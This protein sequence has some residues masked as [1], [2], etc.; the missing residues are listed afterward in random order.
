M[1]TALP[2][3]QPKEQ[4]SLEKMVAFLAAFRHWCGQ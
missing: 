2:K 4:E 3:V 1:A